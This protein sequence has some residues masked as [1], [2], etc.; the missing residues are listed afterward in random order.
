[1]VALELGI[2]TLITVLSQVS[3]IKRP[4]V[5]H[6][7]FIL[8]SEDLIIKYGVVKKC[9]M[10]AIIKIANVLCSGVPEKMK[11]KQRQVP[12]PAPYWLPC[13]N[14]HNDFAVFVKV[15]RALTIAAA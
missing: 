1:M 3:P 9:R 12:C 14:V 11:M 5:S 2:T 10:L 15:L 4:V 8:E 6:D 13:N 7:S